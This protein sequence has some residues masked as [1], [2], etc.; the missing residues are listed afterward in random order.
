MKTDNRTLTTRICALLLF[1]I[2]AVSQ[3]PTA[4]STPVQLTTEQKATLSEATLLNRRVLELHA[5]QRFEEAVPIAEQ[6]IK[7]R[8]EALGE[9]NA[10]VAEAISNLAALYV[11]KGDYERAETEY[12]KA[13]I[14][15]DNAGGVN[16]H[17][18]YVLDSLAL[19]R[20]SRRDYNKAEEYA[21]RAIDLKEKLLGEQSPQ[22][23][24]SI[25][26][27]IK[28]YE[29]AGRSSQ[30]IALMERVISIFERAK[31]VVDVPS[32]VRYRCALFQT[33]E[34]P[35]VVA[36]IRRIETLMKWDSSNSPATQVGVLN[37]RALSL[38]RPEYP[39]DARAGGVS[40]QVVVEVEI[41]ECGSVA[42][43]K[44]LSGPAPLRSA[45]ER[46]A[47]AARFSPTFVNGMPIRVTGV[48]QYHFVRQ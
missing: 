16:E 34:T 8:R 29:S 11:G 44:V 27:L 24:E 17:M 46:S 31:A 22:L 39:I 5:A 19:L 21:K 47:K 18:G 4:T 3:T 48:I 9:T 40:G 26:H 43:V 42:R 14:L 15:Y 12:R 36:L 23:V 25:N 7:M 10:L 28:I 1:V 6:V 20:W 38:P 45:C 33:K 41:D 37:G 35:E 30:R 32:L 2:E 13:L